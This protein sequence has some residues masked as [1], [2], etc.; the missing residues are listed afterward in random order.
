VLLK[1]Q[2]AQELGLQVLMKRKGMFAAALKLGRRA[3]H[4]G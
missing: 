1:N 4:K 3:M 2:L